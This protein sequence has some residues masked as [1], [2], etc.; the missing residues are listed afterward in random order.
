MRA[1]AVGDMSASGG[2]QGVCERRGRW[3]AARGRE[4]RRGSVSG[5]GRPFERRRAACPPVER[6]RRRAAL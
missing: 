5:G 4:R 6:E 3:T 1:S 2:M